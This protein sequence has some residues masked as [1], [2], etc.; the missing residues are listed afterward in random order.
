M[1]TPRLEIIY[2]RLFPMRMRYL[3]N[4]A[5]EDKKVNLKIEFNAKPS[6]GHAAF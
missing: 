6:I 2:R 3:I 4:K 1:E 5:Q